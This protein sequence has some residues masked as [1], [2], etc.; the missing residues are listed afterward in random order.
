MPTPGHL[1]FTHCSWTKAE[2]CLS[3]QLI[4]LKQWEHLWNRFISTF[5]NLFIVQLI[6]SCI[7]LY[8]NNEQCFVAREI[9]LKP[10]LLCLMMNESNELWPCIN[11][12]FPLDKCIAVFYIQIQK[13]L[14]ISH[15]PS[16]QCRNLLSTLGDSQVFIACDCS[17]L[18]SRASSLWDLCQISNIT[19]LWYMSFEVLLALVAKALNLM[20]W[21]CHCWNCWM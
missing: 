3:L 20:R 17:S 16:P 2:P 8:S 12:A 1:H 7:S 21:V 19:K 15:L 18:K 13:T 6:Q 14:H 10:T 4:W 11:W 5:P 9:P